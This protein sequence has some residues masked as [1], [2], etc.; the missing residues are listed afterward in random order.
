ML[1]LSPWKIVKRKLEQTGAKNVL[2]DADLDGTVDN[3][4]KVD[5]KKIFVSST[6]PT[7]ENTGDIWV[8]T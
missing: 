6:E 5:G 2:Y 3:S 4:D 7:A 8:Q 1:K